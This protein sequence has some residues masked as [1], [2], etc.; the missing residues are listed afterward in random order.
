V[1]GRGKRGCKLF[2]PEDLLNKNVSYTIIKSIPKMTFLMETSQTK[3]IS[4]RHFLFNP[5]A[6]CLGF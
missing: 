4:S 1:R 6:H 3:K 5:Y 2:G